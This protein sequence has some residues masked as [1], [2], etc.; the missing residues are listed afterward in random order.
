MEETIA[1]A[2]AQS[3][4]A[5]SARHTLLSAHWSYKSYRANYLP[6]VTL[7]SDPY[8]N[9]AINRI[10]MSDGT[11]RFVEQNLLN[12]D[13]SLSISQNIP[14]TGGSLS[15]ISSLQR[16]DLLGNDTHSWQ[17]SPV[18]VSYRQNI[19]G[20]N[21]HKWS[22]RIE[23]LEYR[24][25]KKNY[26]ETVELI[27]SRAAIKFFALAN[28][29]SNYEMAKMNYAHADTLYTYAQG[30][31]NIG[32]ISENEM[33][34]LELSKLTRESSCMSSR[35]SLENSM[36]ELRSYLG[37]HQDVELVVKV[38][39]HVPDFQIDFDKALA[40]AHANSPDMLSLQ[41]SK[42][43]SES[44][45]AYA[46]SNAGLKAD[47]Y[48]R[49]GLTQTAEKFKEA[50]RHPSQQQYVSVGFSLPIL[51]WGSSKGSIRRARSNRD[52]VYSQAEQSKIDFDKNVLNLVQ[53]FNLQVKHLQIAARSNETAQRSAEVTRRLFL[54][55]KC[56]VLE[57][58][59][60][61]SEKDSARRSYISAVSTYWSLYYTLRS[62][63]LYDFEHDILLE[64]KLQ[65]IDIEKL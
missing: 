3:Y 33:L 62:I 40:L 38:D 39:T 14:W 45:V 26:V 56:S 20:Y 10:T 53:Q 30:R 18:S 32:T 37:I 54:L 28:A 49:F 35:I 6:K 51:D 15:V 8:L 59:N 23:P 55:G 64:D 24:R 63:T 9:R 25:A 11:E 12:T 29:Q 52:L 41:I 27:A 22:R 46:R 47:I 58:N 31:Y 2:C 7:T 61:I 50:Y 43:N 60:S 4:D 57:L 19:F 42:L 16:I 1:R 65:D 5:Q 48:L 21:S 13:V 36:Q 44:N 17:T 34:Q